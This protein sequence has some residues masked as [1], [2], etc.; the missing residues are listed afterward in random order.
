MENCNCVWRDVSSISDHTFCRCI[1]ANSSS[2]FAFNFSVDIIYEDDTNV[3]N[4]FFLVQAIIYAAAYVAEMFLLLTIY[5]ILL[6]CFVQPHSP[7]DTKRKQMGTI[8]KLHIIL[9]IILA[10]LYVAYWVLE[11]RYTV[12]GVVQ[13]FGDGVFYA[14]DRKPVIN[15]LLVAYRALYVVASV[16]VILSTLFLAVNA[17]KHH[18]RRAVNSLKP[19]IGTFLPFDR[20]ASVLW[21]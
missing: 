15:Q 16:E 6:Q 13:N 17:Q 7:D 10:A 19:I 14:V 9:C 2:S 1:F 11:L 20:A 4:V 8:F 18:L 5:T 3:A 12:E 21:A